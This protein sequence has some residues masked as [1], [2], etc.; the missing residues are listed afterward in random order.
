MTKSIPTRQKSVPFQEYYDEIQS[1]MKSIAGADDLITGITCKYKQSNL[2]SC[3]LM[4]RDAKQKPWSS[5]ESKAAVLH[6][7]F[8]IENDNYKVDDEVSEI[9]IK[10]AV[11][12]VCTGCQQAAYID[13][14]RKIEK[15][16]HSGTY[17]CS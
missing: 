11:N 16:N 14:L 9:V 17:I 8:S 1:T 13:Q 5:V 6:T 2:V 3:T 10:A 15:L 4:S 12:F 7:L